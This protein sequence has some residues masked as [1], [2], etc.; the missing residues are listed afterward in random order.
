MATT[1][2]TFRKGTRV[3]WTEAQ[4][5]PENGP[6]F[7]ELIPL[8][9]TVVS[10]TGGPDVSVRVDDDFRSLTDGDENVLIRR[11]WLCMPPHEHCT[12]CQNEGLHG[13]DRPHVMEGHE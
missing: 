2:P 13:F 5:D 7:D 3:A 1:V 9:G 6:E 4:A 8:E 11:R 12:V 10:D